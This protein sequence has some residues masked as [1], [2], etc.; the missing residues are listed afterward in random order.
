MPVKSLITS[1]DAGLIAKV[2]DE[3]DGENRLHV[4][5]V[6]NS[7]NQRPIP[8]TFGSGI[9]GLPKMISL[10]YNQ[11]IGSIVNNQWKRVATYTVPVGYSGYLIRF[12]SFQAEA[13]YSRIAALMTMGRLN[14]VTNVYTSVAYYAIPQWTSDLEVDVTQAIGSAANVTITIG[15]TNEL[16]I[17]DR[18]G[19]V[20][21]PKSSIIG[22]RLSVALQAGDIG[23]ISIQ[24][25]SVA[26]TSSAGAIDILG[27]VQLGY[28][29]DGGTNFME[30]MYS[31]GAVGF[32]E[33]TVL[34]LEHQGGTVS[35]S[36]RFDFLFQLVQGVS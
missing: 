10:F 22:T 29:E 14:I 32:P 26:P 13:A 28:H 9:A 36:R 23:V 34:V 15:Y 12:T 5:A 8:I 1:G 33:G 20:T 16:G 25:V 3:L 24:S 18:V 7:E 27:F 17:S 2:S 4:D 11:T 31:P 19:T 35:K 21:I 30:T 6:I